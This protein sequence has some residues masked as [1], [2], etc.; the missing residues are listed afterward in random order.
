MTANAA[1]GGGDF[2]LKPWELHGEGREFENISNDFGRAAMT[3]EQGLAGLGTPWGT[4]KPGH[5]FGAAYTEAQPQLVAGLHGLASQLGS[6]GTGLHTM[7][8]SVSGTEDE[9]AASFAPGSHPGTG[10]A[11]TTV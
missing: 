3:L 7:A 8:D 10:G 5:A 11:P 2:V 4:D 9:V 6:V 1:G